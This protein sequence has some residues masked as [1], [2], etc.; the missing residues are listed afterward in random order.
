MYIA[1][2]SSFDFLVIIFIRPQSHKY[3]DFTSTKN[4]LSS[5]RTDQKDSDTKKLTIRLFLPPK[6]L[7]YILNNQN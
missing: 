5:R 2:D 1:I 6:I 7:Q 3:S 4:R